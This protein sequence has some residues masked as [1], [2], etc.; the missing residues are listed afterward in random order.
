MSL[1]V[2]ACE[3]RILKRAIG[4]T[5]VALS[6]ICIFTPQISLLNYLTEWPIEII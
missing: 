1:W 4:Y 3:P 2:D 6:Y 5:P